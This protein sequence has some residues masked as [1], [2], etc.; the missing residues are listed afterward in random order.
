MQTQTHRSVEQKT[1][2]PEINQCIYGQLVYEKGAKNIQWGKGSI[3]NKWCWENWTAARKRM[4]LYHY[5][6]P[7]TKINL[8]WI[9]DLNIRPETIRFPEEN[10]GSKLLDIGL[11]DDFLN[12]TSKA[13]STKAKISKWDY[14]KLKSFC[15][16]KETINK[17]KTQP[18][19]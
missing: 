6:I 3:F 9:K 13:K 8:K 19:E 18:T 10:I 5:L 17:M 4:K 2:S 11:G 7:Y 15:T 14:I 12:L 16:A 1:E